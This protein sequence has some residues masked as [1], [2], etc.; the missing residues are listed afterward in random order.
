MVELNLVIT[1]MSH[2]FSD[3]DE[4]KKTISIC[5]CTKHLL[6]AGSFCHLNVTQFNQSHINMNY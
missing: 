5:T 3:N 4:K 1:L 2:L 6:F